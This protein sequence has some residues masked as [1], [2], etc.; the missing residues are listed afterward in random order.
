MFLNLL[1]PSTCWHVHGVAPVFADARNAREVS[2]A[3]QVGEDEDEDLCKDARQGGHG[4][5]SA[6]AME[7]EVRGDQFPILPSS[8]WA[9]GV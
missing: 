2:E 8:V 1:V 9:V 3:L 7:C 6:R 4:G 5:R